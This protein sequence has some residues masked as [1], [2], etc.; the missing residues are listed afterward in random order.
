MTRPNLSAVADIPRMHARLRPES[1]AMVY[2]GVPTSYGQLDRRASK[3]ANGLIAE[4]VK[5]QA[6][7]AQLDK[8]SDIFFELLFGT[9]KA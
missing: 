1:T 3:V 4:G 5:P 9:T 7:I 8:N 2:N 6:R